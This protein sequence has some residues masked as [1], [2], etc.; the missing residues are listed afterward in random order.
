MIEIRYLRK[1]HSMTLK[2]HAGAGVEGQDLICC[3][4]SIITYTLAANVRQMQ[5]RGWISRS[6][7]RLAPG[8]AEISCIPRKEAAAKV[9]DRM[10]T[11]CM[12][13]LLL[14]RDYPEFVRVRVS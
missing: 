5:K 9:G 6:A 3:A 4:V 10:D 13:Y 1:Q 14:A 12:G 11:V 7:I 2:G 8:D